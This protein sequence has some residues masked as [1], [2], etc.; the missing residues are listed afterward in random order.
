MR[1]KIAVA[2]ALLFAFIPGLV[3]AQSSGPTV[4][5]NRWD[6]RITVRA[7]SDQFQVA[8]TQEVHITGGTVKHG[9][10][11]W[12][13][14]V[15]LQN[16]YLIV[17]NDATPQQLAQNSADQPGT[18]RVSTANNQTTLDYTLPTPQNSGDVYTVQINYVATT[19]TPGL[20]D[21]KIVPAEHDFNVKS[22]TATI[23][24]P[25]GQ[26][27]DQTLVHV[28]TSNGSATVNGN[29]VV[30][31]SQGPIAANQAFAIQVP[32]G[33]GVGAAAA[34]GN[35]DPNANNGAANDPASNPAFPPVSQPGD[36]G[37]IQLPGIGTIVA[38]LCILGI[39]VLFG[40][41]SLVRNLLGGLIGGAIN[42]GT[43]GLLGG[44]SSSGGN[45]LG[46]GQNQSGGSE[47]GFRPSDGGQDRQIGNIGN[48]KDSGGGGSFS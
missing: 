6:A 16:V 11:F 43:G 9:K 45:I 22:S 7:N 28:S 24:F 47:R 27:P 33:A 35:T 23:L 29:T 1:S 14:P 36:T 44:G 41:G 34:A 2:L 12:T 20:V 39:I 4:E 18:Y 42:R 46:G 17:G 40:G 15:Q 5:W 19:P 31:K 21:W 48:D 13:T 26:A 30:I 8:E 32:F 25:D 37:S 3:F 38:I 10:R